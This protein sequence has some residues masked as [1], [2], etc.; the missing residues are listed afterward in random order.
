MP[1][2]ILPV[3]YILQSFP[4]LTMTFIYREVLA[5]QRLGLDILTFSIWKPK[6]NRIAPESQH[7]TKR[8]YYVFPV[9]VLKF[10]LAHLY[11]LLT[12]PAGYIGTAILVLTRRGELWK[13]WVRTASHFGQAVYLAKEI[14]KHG[15]KH[16]HAHF[17]HNAASIAMM[18]SSLL[19][20]SFSF[21]AHNILFTDRILLKEKIR[22]ARFIIAISKFTRRFIIDLLPGMEN[23]VHVVHC[24]LSPAEFSP[25]VRRPANEIPVVLFVAQ[26]AERKGAP[27]FVEACRILAERNTQF[28]SIIIGSGPQE[29]LVE[30]L[31]VQAGLKN[32]V[33][34]TGALFQDQVKEYLD[35]ADIFVSPCIR[36]ARGDM[37]GIPV[38]LMEAMAKE[39]ASVSTR[40][41]GIP[42]LIENE[43]SGLLVDEGS[44]E[45]LA[46]ALQR[47]IDNDGLRTRLGKNARQKVSQ[48]FDIDRSANQIAKLFEK[49]LVQK[50]RA[51]DDRADRIT[52]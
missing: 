20:L 25:P 29:K 39:I 3:A 2:K 45:S 16:L 38:A 22:R 6:K 40:V 50:T 11:F 9:P 1:E 34:L 52:G 27:V 23:K 31:V 30:K 48:D 33:E 21:T 51:I 28:R 37:D 47:L 49:Y 44:P 7:L 46:D 24:G 12:S 26:L 17:S 15:I 4:G 18:I 35:R 5:L 36:T 8:T 13:N 41:S 19:G 14:K 10:I 42:E 32:V 43:Q